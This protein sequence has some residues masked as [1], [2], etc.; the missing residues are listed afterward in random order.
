MATVQKTFTFATTTESFVGQS[1]GD[2]TFSHSSSVGNPSGSLYIDMDGNGGLTCPDGYWE[3]ETTW[4]DLGVPAGSTVTGVTSA[5]AD[6]QVPVCNRETTCQVDDVVLTDDTTNITLASTRS[7]TGPDSTWYTNNGTDSTGHSFASDNTVYIRANVTLTLQSHPTAD[8]QLYIDNITFTITYDDGTTAVSNDL[9]LQWNV[10]DSV[11][12]DL[13]LQWGINDSVTN[14]LGLQWGINSAASSDLDLYWNINAPTITYTLRSSGGDYSLMSLWEDDLPASLV[15][16]DEIW[17]LNVY[18]DWASGLSDNVVIAER[19][20]D[21]THYAHIHVLPDERH[22]GTPQTGFYLKTTWGSGFDVNCDYTLIEYMD[23]SK[24]GTATGYVHGY[25]ITTGDYSKLVGCIVTNTN[26]AGDVLGFNV[27]AGNVTLINCLADSDFASDMLVN[28]FSS[29]STAQYLNCG[30]A[31]STYGYYHDLATD[32]ITLKNCFAITATNN[33]HLNNTGDWATGS[34]NNAADDAATNT[35]PGSNPLTTN[36]TASTDFVDAANSDYHIG[37]SSILYDA[38]ADLS[39]VFTSDIDAEAITVWSIGIDGG[40]STTAVSNDLDLYWNINDA[41]SSDLDLYWNVNDSVTN[42]LDLYW[43][44]NNAISNDLS[45]YW[46][47]NNSVNQDLTLYWGVNSSAVNDLTL[48]WGINDSIVNDLSLQWDINEV[49]SNDLGLQWGVNGSVSDDLLLQWGIN[50]SVDG[51]LTFHWGINSQATKDLDLYWG[52]NGSVNDDLTLHWNI[53]EQPGAV[54]N[55]LTLQWGINDS[56]NDDL[57][58]Y[59]GVNDSASNDLDL[60]W[61]VNGAISNDLDLAWGINDSVDTDLTLQW[62][63]NTTVSDDLTLHWDISEQPGSVSN[64]LTL[65]WGINSLVTGDLDLYWN[66]NNLVS[67]D[68]DLQWGINDTVT[69]DLDLYWNIEQVISN[70]LTLHWDISEQPGQVTNDLTLQWG[71]QNNVYSTTELH[72]NILSAVYKDTL[73][74][75]DINT[76]AN[77]DITFQW[78]INNLASNDLTLHWGITQQTAHDL[79]LHWQINSVQPPEYSI[80][81]VVPAENRTLVVEPENRTLVVEPENRTLIVKP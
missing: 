50:D 62:G 36:I 54:S 60:Q 80:I 76:S 38:G 73:L 13:D 40:S 6:Y 4:E 24:E 53:A 33:Y 22:D 81:Y 15:T 1:V 46:D 48:H 12:S 28:Y 3:L 17:R 64:D 39:A 65:S 47:I 32:G 44:I 25:K 18:N 41:V 10:N 16:D 37:T 2:A 56:V 72:W 61:G 59:W 51:D 68:L 70:D 14:D 23:I 7:W 27:N 55:D 71:I 66:V 67:S 57:T 74:F 8:L 49:I 30:S 9:D 29:S 34:T 78:N 63:I 31:G 5:S 75:W 52:V 42:D 26:T 20:T 77:S 69:N 45:L 35:P 11:S 21:A 79:T 58:L 19:T 43:N